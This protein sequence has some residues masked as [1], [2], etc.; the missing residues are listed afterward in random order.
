[1]KASSK[2][3]FL[4]EFCKGQ[5]SGISIGDQIHTII[6]NKKEATET[7]KLITEIL[8]NNDCESNGKSSN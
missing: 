7:L 2:W 5:I 4:S 3:D 6:S 1:M 8:S